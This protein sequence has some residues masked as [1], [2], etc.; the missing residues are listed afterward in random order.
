MHGLWPCAWVSSDPGVEP[1]WS[2]IPPEV[3]LMP[4]LPPESVSRLPS[5]ATAAP[6]FCHPTDVSRWPHSGCWE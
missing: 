4:S 5:P 2:F 6:V 1:R 3:T